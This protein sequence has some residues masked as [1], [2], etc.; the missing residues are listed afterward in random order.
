MTKC[1][2]CQIFNVKK[3]LASKL[4]LLLLE[5]VKVF[6]LNFLR[7]RSAFDSTLP[8]GKVDF[9]PAFDEPGTGE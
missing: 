8:R 7:A 4:D 9:G 2:F 1:F 3:F 6:W 5:K